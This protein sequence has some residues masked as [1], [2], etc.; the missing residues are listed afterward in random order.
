M[1]L[2]WQL[3]DMFPRPLGKEEELL[4]AKPSLNTIILLILP[5]I[6]RGSERSRFVVR[7]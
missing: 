2:P 7:L 6:K 4:E 5:R 3:E 1:P